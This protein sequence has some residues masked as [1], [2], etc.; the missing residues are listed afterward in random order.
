MTVDTEFLFSVFLLQKCRTTALT[1]L[2]SGEATLHDD[3]ISLSYDISLS[4]Q[5]QCPQWRPQHHKIPRRRQILRA[6]QTAIATLVTVD[7]RKFMVKSQG[8]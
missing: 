3:I 6:P 2:V 5:W 4:P 8:I 1:A 7:T